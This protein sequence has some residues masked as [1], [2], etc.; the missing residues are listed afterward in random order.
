MS[1]AALMQHDLLHQDQLGLVKEAE[2]N[3]PAPHQDHLL[4]QTLGSWD[5]GTA[6][7]AAPP[8]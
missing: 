3:T 2:K 4:G 6:G 1:T 7:L 5:W 8:R